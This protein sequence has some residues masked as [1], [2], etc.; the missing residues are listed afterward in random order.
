[1]HVRELI[2]ILSE[3][4]PDA[5]VELAVIAPVDEDSDDITVDR[6]PVD[7]VLPWNDDDDEGLVIWLIGGEDDDVDAFLDAVEQ[8][9]PGHDTATPTDGRLG[10]SVARRGRRPSIVA[11]PGDRSR[12]CPRRPSGYLPGLDG[13]RAISVVAVLLYHADMPWLP[14]GF[15]GVEVFFVI[16]GYLIT[17]LLTAGARAHVDDLAARLLAARAPGACS[18]PSTRCWRRCRWSCCSSTA[19][20][21]P[22]WPARSGRR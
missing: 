5:E 13:L 18:P 12:R 17:L 16:S 9:T 6:Y 4:P 19:R 14:G 8:D 3:Q 11:M 1:M 22:S 10:G 2:D 21:R 20:T 15:L 7:G